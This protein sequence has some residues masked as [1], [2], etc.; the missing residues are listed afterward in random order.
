MDNTEIILK[1]LT[2]EKLTV[3]QISKKIDISKSTINYHVKKLRDQGKIEVIGKK[4]RAN[5]F[6]ISLKENTHKESAQIRPDISFNLIDNPKF[7]DI[8]IFTFVNACKNA[9]FR[10]IQDFLTSVGVL[11]KNIL[12]ALFRNL[13]RDL[14]QLENIPNNNYSKVL[15]FLLNNSDKVI[16]NYPFTMNFQEAYIFFKHL[17]I[18]N[19][20][21][22]IQFM[23][24]LSKKYP[25]FISISS[26]RSGYRPD[27][28]SIKQIFLDK[29][30]FIPKGPWS[31]N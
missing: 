10:K 28:L 17:D 26:S 18:D 6:F 11:N 25:E 15:N 30:Q 16:S 8:L 14:L 29:V 12:S 13:D 21:E 9:S 22:F 7:I 31:V 27:L 2:E 4:G 1:L 3:E 24:D 5:I 19:M 20:D 23:S